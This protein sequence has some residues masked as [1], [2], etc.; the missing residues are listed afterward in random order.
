MPR[1]TPSQSDAQTL[2]EF[3]A[4]L[5]ERQVLR[6]QRLGAHNENVSADRQPRR[7]QP[8]AFTIARPASSIALQSAV[9]GLS[10]MSLALTLQICGLI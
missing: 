6:R 4:A 3:L 8:R 7:L 1:I 10:V 2:S 9:S 5:E